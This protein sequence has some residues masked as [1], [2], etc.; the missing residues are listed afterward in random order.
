MLHAFLYLDHSNRQATRGDSRE[1]PRS[2]EGLL[3]RA[4]HH[5]PLDECL[6]LVEDST[7]RSTRG[8]TERWARGAHE[9]QRGFPV[10]GLT[11]FTK[12]DGPWAGD[13]WRAVAS[14]RPS[15][16]PTLQ[17]PRQGTG[18]TTLQPERSLRMLKGL[19]PT[20]GLCWGLERARGRPDS[21]ACADVLLVS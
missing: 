6:E 21:H 5:P 10:S 8:V 18:R 1:L 16:F 14:G 3:E 20:S 17:V 4:W 12:R 2:M 13:C 11:E 15:R 7:E 9:R 19:S